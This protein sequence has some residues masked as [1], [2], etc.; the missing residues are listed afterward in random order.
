MKTFERNL[1]VQSLVAALFLVTAIQQSTSAAVDHTIS[2]TRIVLEFDCSNLN[3]KA[4]NEL[5]LTR[6]HH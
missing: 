3:E 2:V 1:N 5:E 4:D 6:T